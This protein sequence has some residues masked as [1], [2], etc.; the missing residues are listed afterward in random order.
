MVEEKLSSFTESAARTSFLHPASPSSVSSDLWG[1]ND[2]TKPECA[3]GL[4]I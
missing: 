2:H 4:T 3:C 1:G